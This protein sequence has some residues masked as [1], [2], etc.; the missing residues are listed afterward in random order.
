MQNKVYITGHRRP[1]SDSIVAA[2]AYAELKNRQGINA[3]ACRLG[4][5]QEETKYLL[6]RFHFNE[7]MLFEDARSTFA[8]IEMDAALSVNLNTT[9]YD[10]LKIMEEAN[11]KSIGI[12]NDKNHLVGFA[13]KS[14]LSKAGLQDTVFS[15]NLLKETPLSNIVS[16]LDGRLIYEASNN[17]FSGHVSI[18]AYNQRGVEYYDVLDRMVIVGNDIEAQKALIRKGAATLLLVWCEEVEDEVIALAKEYNCSILISGH[19]TMNTSRYLYFSPPVKLLMKKQFTW[20]L[21]DEFVEDAQKVMMKSRYRSYPVVDKDN[22]L[23]GFVSRYHLLNY[24]RKQVILVDHNEYSQSVKGIEH[25]DLIEVVDHHRI[26]DIVT[27]RPI[28]FRN[29]IIG[30]AST[31]ITSIYLENQLSIS[32]N[33]AGLLLGAIISD[34]LKFRSPTTTPK[35]KGMAIMLASIA[36]LDIDTFASEMF[37]VS[38]NISNKTT[39]E[40]INQDIKRFEIDGHRVLIGQVI[41]SNLNEVKMI[42]T[43]LQNDLITYLNEKKADLVILAFTSIIDNGSIFYGCGDKIDA[44]WEAFPNKEG[45]EHSFHEDVL[46]RKNQIVPAITRTILS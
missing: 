31:I 1:D 8:E 45:E 40:L 16:T 3:V 14:D 42:E 12:T 38:S 7:P 25:A 37:A 35:D 29:E 23:V 36:G 19:G 6:E 32:K 15:V 26:C 27:S 33:L 30:S 34:T 18:V 21:D 2:I 4:E 24:R 46:S 17:H 39:K 11:M 41:V 28:S 43:Q 20:F 5:L 44:L 22:H 9:I 10:A 13:S